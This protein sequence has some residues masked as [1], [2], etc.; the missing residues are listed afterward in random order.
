MKSNSFFIDKSV[1]AITPA[2]YAFTSN[3]SLAE[4]NM[5]DFGVLLFLIHIDPK[6]C[7][8]FVKEQFTQLMHMLLC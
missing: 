5:L 4:S 3:S 6:A 8:C 7:K 1:A 2:S